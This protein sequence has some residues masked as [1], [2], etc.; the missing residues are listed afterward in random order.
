VGQGRGGGVRGDAG[1]G[2]GVGGGG[3]GVLGEEYL[4][5]FPQINPELACEE[6]EN[7]PLL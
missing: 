3:G 4:T 1:G 6:V 7:H 5:S 2:G